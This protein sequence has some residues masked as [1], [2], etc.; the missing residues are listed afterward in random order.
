MD[1]QKRWGSWRHKG[2]HHHSCNDHFCE[3]CHWKGAPNSSECYTTNIEIVRA[4]ENGS[5]I[6]RG[7]ENNSVWISPKFE[8]GMQQVAGVWELVSKTFVMVIMKN[9][10]TNKV[11]PDMPWRCIEVLN[12]PPF[13]PSGVIVV[14]PQGMLPTGEKSWIWAPMEGEWWNLLHQPLIEEKSEDKKEPLKEGY[15]N[16]Y[17]NW[18]IPS[19]WKYFGDPDYYSGYFLDPKTGKKYDCR[20]MKEIHQI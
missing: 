7:G 2:T 19:D 3:G 4:N 18:K 15:A 20:D 1:P 16:P 13:K 12:L 10:R 6:G 9:L 17:M 11:T 5:F 8:R 14:H